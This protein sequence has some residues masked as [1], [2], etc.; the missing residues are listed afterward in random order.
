MANSTF[1]FSTTSYTGSLYTEGAAWESTEGMRRANL[2]TTKGG[3][4]TTGADFQ[5]MDSTAMDDVCTLQGITAGIPN[6]VNLTSST[7]FQ[8]YMRSTADISGA[9]P[10]VMVRLLSSSGTVKGTCLNLAGTSEQ[11]SISPNAKGH[12]VYNGTFSSGVNLTTAV[13]DRLIVEY[14]YSANNQQKV[15]YIIGGTGPDL[16][17]TGYFN[18]TT[19]VGWCKVGA[20]LF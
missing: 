14:G 10:R 6:I 18:S 3:N 16:S 12:K 2:A 19:G 17:L 4:L 9:C 20:E 5:P 7:T 15:K 8:M 1:Y 13:G 11:I